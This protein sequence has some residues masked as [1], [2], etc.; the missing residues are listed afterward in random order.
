MA[1]QAAPIHT[2]WSASPPRS[3]ALERSPTSASIGKPNVYLNQR[4]SAIPSAQSGM[5][6]SGTSRPESSNSSRM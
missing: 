6:L 2:N 4:A 1:A 5:T 3:P